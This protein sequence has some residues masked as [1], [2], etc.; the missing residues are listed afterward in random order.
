MFFLLYGCGQRKDDICHESVKY[1]L[2]ND[3]I[4]TSM[5]GNL[6]VADKYLIWEDPFADDYFVNVHDVETGDALGKMGNVGDGP[7]EFITGEIN[8]FCINN[9][10]FA[11]DVNSLTKGSLSLDSLVSNQNSFI[12]LTSEEREKR[13]RMMQLQSNVFVNKSMDGEANYFDAIINGKKSSFGAYPVN[14]VREHVGNCF[15]YDSISGLFACSAFSIPYLALYEKK[16]DGFSLKWEI[17]SKSGY[18]ISG[19]RLV[20]DNNNGGISGITLSKDYI[21][22]LQRDWSSEPMDRHA[23]GRDVKSLSHTLFLYD[24]ESNLLRIVDL[25]APVVRI[26]ANRRNNTLY[27]IIVDPEFMLVK[28]E[29]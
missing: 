3:S 4:M 17:K 6:I 28:Y 8:P 26:A 12:A 29:L 2:L 10:F 13:P 20:F 24:Y 14:N 5:P 18:E 11:T 23:A 7:N 21:I 16:Q 9:C 27:A 19:S 15:A 1:H 22:C 25:G